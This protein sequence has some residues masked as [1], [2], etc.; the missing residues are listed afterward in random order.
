MQGQIGQLL[1]DLRRTS[2][3]AYLFIT[4]D[5]ALAC[6]VADEIAVMHGGRIVER[7]APGDL[8]AA[9]GHPHTRALIA[10]VPELPCA[11]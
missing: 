3:L 10:A 9:P 6:A 1:V 2:G 7:A 4:H 5:L 11:T 8:L